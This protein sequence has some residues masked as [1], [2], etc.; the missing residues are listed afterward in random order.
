MAHPNR[1][2]NGE[3]AGDASNWALGGNAVFVV[4]QGNKELGAVHLPDSGSY[5]EQSFTVG[6]GRPYMVEAAVKGVSGTGNVT[7]TITNSTGTVFTT[8]LAFGNG[9]VNRSERVGLAWG[10]Y[11]LRLAFSSG[12][13][14]VDDVSI[15][16]VIKTRA[17]LAAAVAER[18]GILATQ[19]SMTTV[20]NGAATE[21]HYTD[22]VN[23]GLRAVGACDQAGREDVRYLGNDALSGCLEE[24]E[25]AMLKKLQRY[26][27]TKTDYAIGPRQEH[28]NQIS[29]ALL[30]LTGGAVGGRP[31]SAGRSVKVRKL[32]HR[33]AL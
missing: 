25:L 24:I 6:V 18:L 10:D 3:F 20:P 13:A 22:P 21:G 31:A 29:A 23:E 26:W 11:T 28:M 32:E 30:A 33:N 2:F 8:S 17:E 12:A 4:F 14:Y 16:W 9:W 1:V 27:T 7:L 19:A 15:A 5:V